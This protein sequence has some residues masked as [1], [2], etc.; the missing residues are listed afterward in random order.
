MV[1]V[2]FF[3]PLTFLQRDAPPP[4]PIRAEPVFEVSLISNK[5][6]SYPSS[7]LSVTQKFPL[8]SPPS[9][10]HFLF[11]FFP[12]EEEGWDSFCEFGGCVLMNHPFLLHV[13]SVKQPSE[14]FFFLFLEFSITTL[15]PLID[16]SVDFF[17]SYC[18]GPLPFFGSG[19]HFSFYFQTGL[20]FSTDSRSD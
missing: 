18:H 13:L 16:R 3:F 17:H 8:P 9:S 10:L 2:F 11:F 12:P 15:P 19:H 14:F 5:I 6:A 1:P 20:G 4:F 7:P